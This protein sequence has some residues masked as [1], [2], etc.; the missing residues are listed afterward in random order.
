MI[1]DG[2]KYLFNKGVFH[3]ALGVVDL[4]VA[5]ALTEVVVWSVYESVN[6]DGDRAMIVAVPV[7]P[8]AVLEF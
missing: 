1:V 6:V 7:I 2:V 5:T 8:I 3:K 4:T